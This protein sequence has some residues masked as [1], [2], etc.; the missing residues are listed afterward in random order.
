MKTIQQY[1]KYIIDINCINNGMQVLFRFDNNFGLSVVCHSF[2]FGNHKQ[3][4]EVAVIKFES[5][6][7]W[8]L[9]Y[10]T[11]ITDDV[12]GYQSKEDLLSLIE[13]T[14]LL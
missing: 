7:T 12:L 10:D 2:S 4:F 5:D 1:N 13:R 3:K 14:I 9:N 11:E 6:D 8:F